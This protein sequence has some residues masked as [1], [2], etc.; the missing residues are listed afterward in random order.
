MPMREYPKAERYNIGEKVT[1]L[2]MEVQDTEGGGAE[3]ILSRSSPEFVRTL[4]VQEVPE[5]SDGIISI[6]K[7]VREAG[8]RTKMIVS[9]TDSRVDPVGACVGMRGNRIK[10]VVRELNNEKIDIIP[11]SEDLIV[12]L[13]NSLSPIEIKKISIDEDSNTVFMVV[14]DED[15]PIVIGRKGMNARLTGRLIDAELSVQRLTEHKKTNSILRK[16]LADSEDP[17]LDE[18]LAL[19]GINQLI[20]ENLIDA[21]FDTARKILLANNEDITNVPGISIEMADQ[22]IDAIRK[23][24]AHIE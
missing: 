8:Y 19:E 24:G 14:N 12:L 18:P 2:L 15:F 3:V 22:I 1:A 7:I 16:E 10:N 6:V 11:Y 23:K 13:Q 4:M 20:L 21:G 5:L 9:T 17:T